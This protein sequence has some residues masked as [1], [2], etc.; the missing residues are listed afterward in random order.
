[1]NPA[2]PITAHAL[3]AG[4]KRVLCH[5]LLPVLEHRIT[6]KLREQVC[7]LTSTD[8]PDSS[9]HAASWIQ[10]SSQFNPE[11][12]RSTLEEFCTLCRE[13]KEKIT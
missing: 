9:H 11:L 6:D 5:R 4:Q 13:A 2:S 1:M 7:S 12:T 3:T 8:V 10:G